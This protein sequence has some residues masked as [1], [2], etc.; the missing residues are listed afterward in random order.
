MATQPITGSVSAF[1]AVPPM[2]AVA[3]ILARFEREQLAGFIAVALDLLDTIDG[4]PDVEFNGDEQDS[5]GDE[6]GD[7]AWVEWTTLH[8]A[9]KRG[10]NR[11]FGEEDDEEDDPAEE[12][13]PSGVNDEDGFNI[14]TERSYLGLPN[15]DGPGCVLADSGLVPDSVP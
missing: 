2:P 11:L 5:D 12:D 13:D 6:K 14:P 9:Q 15:G 7:Q 8:G 3:R 10:P 4:D 1:P